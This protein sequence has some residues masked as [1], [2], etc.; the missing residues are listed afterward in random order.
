MKKNL[1]ESV[2]Q[3]ITEIDIDDA[4]CEDFLRIGIAAE[5]GAINLYNRIAKAIKDKEG[6]SSTYLLFKHTSQEEKVH[7]HEFQRLLFDIDPEEE[8]SAEEGV[9]E[10]E[11]ILDELDSPVEPD[12]IDPYEPEEYELESE[13][14]IAQNDYDIVLEKGDRIRIILE[15]TEKAPWDIS[16]IGVKKGEPIV[17]SDD[18][19]DTAGDFRIKVSNADKSR[20]TWLIFGSRKEAIADGWKV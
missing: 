15:Q 4:T 13:V 6:Y 12:I 3:A 8:D 16:E 11:E 18:Y 1:Y 14:T 19:Q 17:V 20:S 9:E 2:L 5:Q 7:V 10:T